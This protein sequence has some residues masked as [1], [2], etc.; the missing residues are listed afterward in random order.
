MDGTHHETGE[1]QDYTPEELKEWVT[2]AF[3]QCGFIK[4]DSADPLTMMAAIEARL[5]ECLLTAASLPTSFVEEWERS[6]EKERRQVS[7]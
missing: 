5:N 7:M 1:A 2:K 6:R 3:Q 4:N